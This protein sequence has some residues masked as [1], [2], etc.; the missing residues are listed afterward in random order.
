ML[1]GGI[2][3]TKKKQIKKKKK[4]QSGRSMIE[5]IGVLAVMALITAGAFVLIASANSTQKR[6]RV[7][8][9]VVEIATGARSLYAEYDT[10]PSI[11]SDTVMSILGKSTQGPYSNTTYSVTRAS[12][13]AF[14]VKLMGLSEDDCNAL[15]IREWKIAS[16]HKCEKN[17]KGD[18][19]VLLI[20]INK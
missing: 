20:T 11:S 2:K 10:L 3:K 13:T 18:G 16:G 17:L 19:W 9:D 5:M 15:D 1:I 14:Y 8:D 7:V 12:D 6:S 4:Q